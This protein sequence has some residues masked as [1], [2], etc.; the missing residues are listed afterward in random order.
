MRTRKHIAFIVT[1]AMIISLLAIGSLAGTTVG[2]LNLSGRPDDSGPGW[3]WQSDSRTLTLD[4][5]VLAEDSGT[6]IYLPDDSTIIIAEGS[7]NMVSAANGHGIWS[8]GRLTIQGSGALSIE[9]MYSGINAETSLDINDLAMLFVDAGGDGLIIGSLFLFTEIDTDD[10]SNDPEQYLT[11]S[12]TD[13]VEIS[14]GYSGIIVR[15]RT[16]ITGVG[17]LEINPDNYGF[18]TDD[19]ISISECGSVII[20]AGMGGIYLQGDL[21]IEQVDLLDISAENGSGIWVSG[22]YDYGYPVGVFSLENNDPVNGQEMTGGNI[23]LVEITELEI[24][25]EYEYGIYA[26]GDV[27]MSDIGLAEISGSYVGII[28]DE[29][30]IIADGIASLTVNAL[31]TYG[32]ALM[33]WQSIGLENIANLVI[34]SSATGLQS[35]EIDISGIGSMSLTGEVGILAQPG[36]R[37]RAATAEPDTDEDDLFSDIYINLSNIDQADFQN[38]YIGLASFGGITIEGC[39]D[40]SIDAAIGEPFA[41]EGILPAA[42]MALNDSIRIRNS[43]V[44]AK[45]HYFGILTGI[46]YTD[47]EVDV[48][49]INGNGPPEMIFAGGDIIISRSFVIA[50]ADPEIGYAAIFAGDNLE[51]GDEGKSRILIDDASVIEPEVYFILDVDID[52]TNSQSITSLAI[53]LITAWAQAANYVEIA[54]DTY[55]VTYDANGGEGTLADPGSPYYV[56]DTVTVLDGT[57]TLAGHE[58]A[59]WNTAADGSGTMYLPGDT[60]V[61]DS[62]IVLFAQ[63]TEVEDEDEEEDEDI[64]P[65]P[66]TADPTGNL[67][68]ILLLLIVTAFA[69]KNNRKSKHYR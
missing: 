20:D 69:F 34:N 4:G 23:S 38:D 45:G 51:A 35:T 22:I 37:L 16:D 3:S 1:I 65:I 26:D 46:V 31:S 33:A 56:G 15:G 48:Y 66:V 21:L 44:H 32:V 39:G 52:D 11:I 14:A 9:A 60:F 28:S 64:I 8:E 12:N 68:P 25:S 19:D 63:Y 5:L 57:F 41:P 29:R 55:T 50:E 58:F 17:I 30:S 59:S 13:A 47:M 36:F 40:L 7:E 49:D 67:A 42:I 6:G 2:G 61:I 43:T 18:S 62:D 10:S 27:W 54:V 24:S 53:E